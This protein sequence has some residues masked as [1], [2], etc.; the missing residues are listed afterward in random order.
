M[1]LDKDRGVG[2]YDELYQQAIDVVRAKNRG[3]ISTVQRVLTIGY[4]RAAYLIEAMEADGIV[5]PPNFKGE[6]QVLPAKGAD[7]DGQR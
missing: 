5:S 1:S 4:N 6:R 7:H 3:S 2:R